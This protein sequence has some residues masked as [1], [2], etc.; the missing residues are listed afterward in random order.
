MWMIAHR[1]TIG[2]SRPNLIEGLHQLP[3]GLDGVE[4]DVLLTVDGV[5]VVHHDL[6]FATADGETHTVADT[7]YLTIRRAEL[8]GGGRIPRLKDYLAACRHCNFPRIFVDLRF[9]EPDFLATVVQVVLASLV[10]DRVL[11]MV[12]NTDQAQWLRQQLPNTP[13][14]MLRVEEENLEE[15]LTLFRAGVVDYLVPTP[16]D[17]RLAVGLEVAKK[18][19]SAGARIGVSIINDPD[20]LQAVRQL[21]CS[22]A[23]TDNPIDVSG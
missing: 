18:A 9:P 2:M 8:A 13:I 12:R 3:D 22:F 14:I 11:F 15:S 7:P 21:G 23:I 19:L 4:L 16:R 20:N 6:D 1:G 5:P 17:H 10:R